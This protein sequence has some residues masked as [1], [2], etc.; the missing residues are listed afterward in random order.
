EGVAGSAPRRVPM[1]VLVS[2][3]YGRARIATAE[4]LERFFFA[5]DLGMVRWERW[6]DRATSRLPGLERRAAM[7][8]EQRRCPPLALSEPPGADWVMVGCRTWTN[9]VRASGPGTMLHAPVW[10]AAVR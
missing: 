8:A 9:L 2:E 4:H 3:H 5:R 1:D 6:E 10:P 7:I